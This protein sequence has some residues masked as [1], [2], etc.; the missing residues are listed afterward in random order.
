MRDGLDDAAEFMI[1]GL[2]LGG[3][4]VRD[5]LL[6]MARSFPDT[7]P[8]EL[9]A[10]CLKIA[11]GPGLQKKAER[12]VLASVVRL[13]TGEPV[14]GLMRCLI[15]AWC[16]RRL[17]GGVTGRRSSNMKDI[18]VQWA[19]IERICRNPSHK[20]EAVVAELAKEFRLKRRRIFNL[21]KGVANHWKSL[22]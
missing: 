1:V 4:Y 2:A 20:R 14:H 18:A 16:R 3:K 10:G 7:K 15:A 17:A 9:V 11:S 12:I 6:V 21:I 5:V 19:F 8:A 13:A 22:R